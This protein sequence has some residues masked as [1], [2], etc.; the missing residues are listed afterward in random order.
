MPTSTSPL[1]PD[2][3]PP[4]AAQNTLRLAVFEVVWLVLIFFLFAGSPPPD[5]GESHYLVKAK[6]YWQPEWCAGDL[7]LESLDAHGTFYWTFGWVTRFFS[8]TA[9]AWIGRVLIWSL[10]AW[11]W[12]RLSWAVVPRPLFSLLS[13]GL[14]LLFLRNFHLAGEWVVG[15]VEAKGFAYV[16][17]FLA[18]E[19]IVRGRWRGAILFAGA[20]AAFHVLVGGW[21]VIAIGFAWICAGKERPSL[22]SL[23]PAALGGLALSLPGLAPSLALTWAVPPETAAEAARIYAFDRL[24]HH[25]VFHEFP[26]WHMVRYALLLAAW[27]AL[28]WWVRKENDLRR[29]QWV[30]A[31]AVLIGVLG[32]L[33]D[34]MYVM[35][36]HMEGHSVQ[37]YQQL[38]ASK[39]RYYWFRMSDSLV[40]IGVALAICA[41]ISRLI[42]RRPK[43]AN[44][45]LVAATLAAGLN[46][47]D[48]CYWRA[49][50]PLPGAILQPRPT[51]D[52]RRQWW[53][54]VLFERPAA[55]DVNANRLAP[56]VP[57]AEWFQH[58]RSVCRWIEASTPRDAR[59]LTPPHQQTFK[60]YAGRAEVVNW[61]DVPQDARG[62]I[63]WRTIMDEVYPRDSEH[64]RHGLAAF[65][66]EELIALAHKYNARFIVIDRTRANRPILLQRVY[67]LAREDN[68]VFDVYVVP[69]GRR[70]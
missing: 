24:S 40:P 2:H 65:T 56:E 49:R 25:L 37:K 43:A 11:S 45:L 27:L 67:P 52:A 14:M 62:L 66:D 58:W 63:A 6:H 51:V 5:V 44:W 46:L 33:L 35:N 69:R 42:T 12:R 15:G 34:Q 23:I 60:W 36:S 55:K 68:P 16:L 8:L 31:G 18:L 26:P 19:A 70:P 17:V 7:F 32:V 28:V 53:G 22:I 3:A 4:P 13:A 48:V 21:T 9:T 10:L 39:L 41:G 64:R 54:S 57:V 61:K 50:L 20:A 30:V 47:A 59:F 38:A 29:L 1:P